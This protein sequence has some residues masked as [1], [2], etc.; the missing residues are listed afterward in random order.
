[1]QFKRK[2]VSAAVAVLSLA[3]FL[4]AAPKQA[5]ADDTGAVLLGAALGVA[6]TAIY[7]NVLHKQQAATQVVGYTSSGCAIYADGHTGCNNVAPGTAITPGAYGRYGA[8]TYGNG[9]GRYAPASR[10]G[11]GRYAGVAPGS[12]ARRTTESGYARR[13]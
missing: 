8:G 5:R 13:R 11:Y 3:L 4:C 10:Y 9:A 7:E 2:V 12:Y 1:M 6:G